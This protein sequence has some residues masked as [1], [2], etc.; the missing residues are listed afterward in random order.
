[1]S[2]LIR[3][4]EL[5]NL[6]LITHRDISQN[7]L[8]RS[9]NIDQVTGNFAITKPLNTTQPLVI[10]PQSPN[11][12]LASF[13]GKVRYLCNFT[14]HGSLDF[15][16]D[17]KFDFIR[18][19]LWVADSAN[20]RV[21]QLNSSTF[22][23]GLEIKNIVLPCV[24]CPNINSGGIF[25]KAFINKN[26]GVIYHYDDG[27]TLLTT[28][29]YDLIYPLNS[30]AV[31]RTAAFIDTLPLS[32]S[33]A[34]DHTR[35]HLW[36]TNNG[37]I[38]MMD[39]GNRQIITN[40]IYT[41]NYVD[42]RGIDI[43]FETGN[44]FVIVAKNVTNQ[45]WALQISNDNSEILS[46]T[47]IA[48]NANMG[49]AEETM[50]TQSAIYPFQLNFTGF[51]NSVVNGTWDYVDDMGYYNNT[52]FFILKNSKDGAYDGTNGFMAWGKYIA[53]YNMWRFFIAQYD[54]YP[55]ISSLWIYAKTST[56]PYG[57]YILEYYDN[58]FDQ[59]NV[60]LNDHGTVS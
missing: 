38:Y 35:N 36:W 2:D 43:E 54:S 11:N 41:D 22:N 30:I 44:C 53:D 3:T 59:P 49:N 16:L 34:F 52:S 24:I 21:L 7:E 13:I 40:N 26:Q 42:S 39:T 51:T 46:S 33:M 50:A 37:I 25:V 60:Y 31:I 20:N 6:E 55:I 45:Y 28:A 32:A 27:G 48:R 15:P 18:S 58:I 5:N 23:V 8:I 19:K 14:G 56:S 10:Y 57:T 17:A 12:P 9:L 4:L 47:Y 29:V 1:M